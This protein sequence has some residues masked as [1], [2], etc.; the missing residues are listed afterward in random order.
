[1]TLDYLPSTSI[2]ILRL[3]NLNLRQKLLLSLVTNFNSNG[4]RMNNESLGEILD[5][6]PSRV[7]KLFKDMEQKG[8]VQIENKQGRNRKIYLQ[9][10][11]QSATVEPST[12]RN[13]RDGE[14]STKR[15]LTIAQSRNRNKEIKD[16]IRTPHNTPKRDGSV[17]VSLW[18]SKDRLLKIKALTDKRRESLKVRMSEKQFAENLPLLIEKVASSDFLCGQNDR[19]WRADIDWLLKNDTN[20]VKVLEGKYDNKGQQATAPLERGKDGLTPRERMA[21]Q[22]GAII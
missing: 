1:M 9:N 7:S 16:N 2:A 17:F 6:W 22:T 5:I 20:Y 15:P 4:L 3:P 11:L 21:K 10:L 14:P 19:G 18:N 13:S 12:K 8:Y